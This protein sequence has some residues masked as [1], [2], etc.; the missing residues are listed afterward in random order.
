MT[1]VINFEASSIPAQYSCMLIQTLF[2]LREY[3]FPSGC[4]G[5]GQALVNRE[6]AHNGLCGDCAVFLKQALDAEKRCC[7]CGKPLITEKDTC[8]SCRKGGP[9]GDKP[10]GGSYNERLVKLRCLFPYTGKFKT[11]LGAYKF[12]KSLGV[13]NF[14]GQC[15]T[16][17]LEGFTHD[18]IRDAAWVPVPPRPGKIKKTG[19]GPDRVP[20]GITG[21]RVQ[22]FRQAPPGCA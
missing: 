21:R 15:L 22:T 10:S 18:E 1:F 16:S 4:G 13:G 2:Y 12:G 11:I 8:L 20:C 17:A 7:V 5:C 3:L 6:E 9:A 19:M 14:L